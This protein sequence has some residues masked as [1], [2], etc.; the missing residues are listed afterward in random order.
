[1]LFPDA[2]VFQISSGKQEKALVILII[3]FIF[4]FLQKL[5]MNYLKTDF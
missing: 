4:E 1:M 3:V 2:A 5:S